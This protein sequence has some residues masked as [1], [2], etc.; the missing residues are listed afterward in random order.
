M[1]NFSLIAIR[2]LSNC[3]ERFLRNLKADHPYIFH[4][5]YKFC[6]KASAVESIN[7]FPNK[8]TNL[9]N[10]PRKEI[11]RKKTLADL[12][13]KVSAVVGK[14]GS[15]KSNLFEFIFLAAYIIA[16]KQLILEDNGV[17][18]QHDLNA[19]LIDT[20]AD[21]D[22]IMELKKAVSE[23]EQLFSDF[24][25]EIYFRDDADIKCIRIENG[26]R[27]IIQ[28]K[29]GATPDT[30]NPV[31]FPA[32]DFSLDHTDLGRYFYTVVINYSLYGLN[33]SKSGQWLKSLFHKNDGYQTPIV[34]NPFRRDGNINVNSELHLA[35]SRLL[36]N[37]MDET[38]TVKNVLSDKPIKSVLFSFDE[39]QLKKIEGAEMEPSIIR[40]LKETTE[41]L[42]DIFV[43]TYEVFMQKECEIDE[44][45]TNI[46][47]FD[48]ITR[49]V[50]K[51]L[52]KI[53]IKYYPEHEFHKFSVELDEVYIRQLAGYL[54]FLKGQNS[55][56]T[57]KLKQILNCVRFNLLRADSGKRIVWKDE[58][59]EIPIDIL[60]ERLQ[61]ATGG[62][63]VLDPL[64][65]MP[66][67][68]YRPAFIL[69]DDTAFHS[70][71]SGE[72]H[73]VHTT[74]A[75]LYHL[76]NLNTVFNRPTLLSFQHVNLML[77]EVELY[78]HPDFQKRIVS[79]LLNGIARLNI[80]NIKCLN[81]LF[82]TH[83]PFILSDIPSQHVLRLD[84]GNPCPTGQE[85][86]GA[87][88][89][90]L[91]A[92][93]FYL[94][95]GFMGDYAQKQITDAI[96]YLEKCEH[97]PDGSVTTP[98][99]KGHWNKKTIKSL[100]GIIGEPVLKQ[101]VEELYYSKF[102]DKLEEEIKRLTQLRK[103]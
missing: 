6:I 26:D 45:R 87:N 58:K 55:H 67:A 53:A 17:E 68:F 36:A 77:D 85:T 75:V 3:A 59:I 7:Y 49:Y 28:F 19:A 20:P 37:L 21:Q 48:K 33:S 1:S 83:S 92:D 8:D 44:F 29:E 96:D 14:N 97:H 27:Q 31:L 66:T 25:A 10:I 79:E 102:P 34:I 16:N 103:L 47:Y 81:I 91:L 46:I 30:Y 5:A 95:G 9:Y 90:D 100:L 56:I 41:T 64:E 22:K 82:S 70:L 38:M 15:G 13:V 57:L 78:F 2:P 39:V 23:H 69:V 101:A 4:Q 51:K 98:Q 32:I 18:A 73:L 93:S 12:E 88:I 71:S 24:A 54:N 11:G 43:S 52:L 84:A 99:G 80:P 40:Q 50:F 63:K 65:Y 35:Q 74:Q 60:E 86:F 89:H 76:I 72:Q 62:I 42:E 94:Q 61:T